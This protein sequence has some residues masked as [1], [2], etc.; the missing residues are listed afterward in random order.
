M[1]IIW[2]KLAAFF[3]LPSDA[4][5]KEI[6]AKLDA[7]LADRK[8][9]ETAP[10]AR[11]KGE[12]ATKAAA[13]TE[14]AAPAATAATEKETAQASADPQLASVLAQLSASL[15][16]IDQRLA[17]LE[18]TEAEEPTGGVTEAATPTKERVFHKNPI[19]QRVAAQL[20][21]KE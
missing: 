9:E 6:D 17:K 13:T 10:E 11:D 21:K 14:A 8:Q 5:E 20:G 2:K 19:N 16:G 4:T 18:S 1:E 15:K 12:T 7:A 3:G